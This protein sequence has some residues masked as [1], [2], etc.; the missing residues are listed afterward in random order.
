MVALVKDVTTTYIPGDPGQAGVPATIAQPGYWSL[1]PQTVCTD[2]VKVIPPEYNPLTGT[3]GLPVSF[4]LGETC[5]TSYVYVYTPPTAASDGIPYA[6]PTPAQIDI[7]LNVGWNSYARSIGKLD[8][9]NYLDYKIKMGTTGALLAVGYAGLEGNPI[10][11]FTHGLMTDVSSISVFESGVVVATLAVNQP[12]T[13]IRIARLVDGRIVYGIDTGVFHISAAPAYLPPEDLYVYGML[14]SGYDEVSTAAFVAGDLLIETGA[15]ISGAGSLAALTE[16]FVE[17]SVVGAGAL[18]ASVFTTANIS[19]LGSL[20]ARAEQFVDASVTG[21]GSLWTYAEA[22]YPTIAYL[23]GTGSLVAS[24]F[25]TATLNG[26]GSLAASTEPAATLTGRGR[27]T[28][29]ESYQGQLIE[30]TINGAGGFLVFADVGGRGYSALPTIVGLGGDTAYGQGRGDL[31][32]FISGAINGQSG[33]VPAAAT[34][35]YGNLPFIVGAARGVDIGIGTASMSLSAFAGVAGDYS[36]GFGSGSLP[37]FVGAGYSGYVPD[38]MLLLIS[39]ALGTMPLDQRLDLIVVLNSSGTLT[40]TLSLTREQ[41]LA[42]LSALQHS[43]SFSML[44]VYSMSALSALSGLSLETVG[45]ENRPDL[46]DNG[47]VWV[48]NLDTNASVQY[49]QYG[50]NSF[51]RRGN[52]YYGVAN[53]GIYELS[54]ATDA[55]NPI[56]AVIDVGQSNLGYTHE[57]RVKNVRVGIGSTGPLHFKVAADGQEYTYPMRTSGTAMRYRPVEIG[58]AVKGYYWNFTLTNP[59]GADFNT[60]SIVLTPIPLARRGHAN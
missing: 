58:W 10:G 5:V 21:S 51:F 12:T 44:G 59:D 60:E 31:P 20:V 18:I 27:L 54:G 29:T 16:Q 13:Q 39:P 36:Y 38:D 15:T 7:S 45:V 41:A 50:F 47:A 22:S 52:D 1:V 33:Y 49:E 25:P 2:V 28:A 34:R 48:V 53:D 19:G 32:Y 57:K 17:A 55:G 35:G 23:G 6:A 26:V 56:S 30:A 9:G 11:S 8:A 14:Y 42:L 3:G 40:S 24:A 4:K 43:S 37:T 46:Y